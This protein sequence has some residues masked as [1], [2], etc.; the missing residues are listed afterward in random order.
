MRGFLGFLA[1]FVPI[2]W[3]WIGAAFY[4]SRFDKD[5]FGQRVLTLL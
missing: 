4:A 3:A 2:W 1:L 5:D